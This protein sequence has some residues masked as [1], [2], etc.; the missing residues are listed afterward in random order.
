MSNLIF[1]PYNKTNFNMYEVWSVDGEVF[2]GLVGTIAAFVREG[3]LKYSDY[4]YDLYL[5]IPNGG[6]MQ[7]PYYGK[8]KEE[9][10]SEIKYH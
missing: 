8:T 6:I 2:F 5:Y 9:A 3:L 10:V 1:K 7:Y 4:D